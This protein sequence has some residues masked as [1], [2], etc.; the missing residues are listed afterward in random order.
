M[1]LPVLDKP[2]FTIHNLPY[3]VIKTAN[4]SNPRCAIA[5]GGHA[6]DLANYARTGKLKNL[7]SGHNFKLETIFAEV[8]RSDRMSLGNPP[9]RLTIS[10]FSMR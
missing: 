4:D 8:S 2:P 10:V 6:L 5:I 3:G 1:S 7:E 9:L